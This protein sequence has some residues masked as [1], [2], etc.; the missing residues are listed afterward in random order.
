M[1]ATTHSDLYLRAVKEGIQVHVVHNASI[2]NAIAATGISIYNVGRAISIPFFDGSWRPA[3]FVE[4]IL[5]NYKAGMHSLM[6]LDIK[7]HELN[8]KAFMKGVERYDN[9]RYMTCAVAC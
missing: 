3:S 7:T 1:C 4:K 6:L 9:P 5:E 8:M 2:I